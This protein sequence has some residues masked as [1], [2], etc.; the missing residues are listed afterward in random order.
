M[1]YGISDPR[2]FGAVGDGVADD[3]QAVRSAIDNIPA[4]GGVLYFPPG[5]YLVREHLAINA[6]ARAVHVRGEGIGVS[7]IEWAEDASGLGMSIC[8]CRPQQGRTDFTNVNNLSF[9]VRQTNKGT[10]LKVDCGG[11]VD[12]GLRCLVNRVNP[13]TTVHQCEFRG[14]IPERSGSAMMLSGSC[15][16]VEVQVQACWA[17]YVQHGIFISDKLEGLKV[18]QCDFV[19]VD[20]GVRIGAS[21]SC[22]QLNLVNNHI[23][24]AFGCI[25]GS[26]VNQAAIMANL[27]Y[28]DPDSTS[29]SVGVQLDG[30]S[31][32]N[33]IANNVFVNPSPES[34]PALFHAIVLQGNCAHNLCQGNVFQ[35]ATD[36]VICM[37][38]AHDNI[39]CGSICGPAVAKPWTDMDGTNRFYPM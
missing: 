25:N 21:G 31:S 6:E 7:C 27:F 3:T 12:P 26:N 16:N 23:N 32:F 30:A 38:G 11:Q 18:Q 4:A 29:N 14:A 9:Y 35:R 19:A 15:G 13:R 10:A 20:F 17:F 37:Q 5:T 36:A 2:E 39:C 28:K 24:A 22:L 8:Q 33:I 1:V 34:H